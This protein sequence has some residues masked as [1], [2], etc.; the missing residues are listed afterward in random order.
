METAVLPNLNQAKRFIIQYFTISA[1][2]MQIISVLMYGCEK[3][4]NC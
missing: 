3:E 4:R 2:S 1:A